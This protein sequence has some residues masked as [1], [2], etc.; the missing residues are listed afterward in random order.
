[1]PPCVRSV[2]AALT[3]C[4]LLALPS[5]GFAHALLHEVLDGDAVTIRLSFPGGDQ[6]LFESYEVYAPGGGTPF[7][8]GRV[9]AIGELSFRPDRE[10]PWR[11]RVVTADG[12]GAVIELDVNEAGRVAAVQGHHDHAAGYWLRVLAALGYL[13]GVFGLLVLWRQ[14]RRLAGPG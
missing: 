14:R 3:A 4:L 1:M 13:F 10:G 11:I 6:P 2:A 9:N 12:H 5:A 7:Q 8:A